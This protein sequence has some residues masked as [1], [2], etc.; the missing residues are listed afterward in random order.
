MSHI[1]KI[2][3]VGV[4][5]VGGVFAAYLGKLAHSNIQLSAIARGDTLKN[6]R[7]HGLTWVDAQ[8]EE[9]SVPLVATDTPADL[10]AQDLVIVSVKGPS[11]QAIAPTIK[12]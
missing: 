6:L 4:G 8:G 3:I 5:A 10:W 12:V 1:K 7:A 2:A 11:L 9:H